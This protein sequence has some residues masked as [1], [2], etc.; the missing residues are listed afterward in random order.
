MSI[1]AFVD[2][3]PLVSSLIPPIVLLSY[4]HT[5]I[6]LGD[7]SRWRETHIAIANRKWGPATAYYGLAHNL[8]PSC[9]TPYHQLAV[10]ALETG[11]HLQ[12]IYHLYRA[13]VV[14]DPHP[15][16]QMSLERTFRKVLEA[17]SKDNSL[18]NYDPKIPHGNGKT[19]F[20][21]YVRLHAKCYMGLD[22]SEEDELEHDVLD[23]LKSYIR[24]QPN[25]ERL[26]HFVLINVA[27]GHL[28]ETRLKGNL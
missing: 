11:S 5:L 25:E 2:T 6:R 15:S 28:A 1:E 17:S 21:N 4:F 8:C 19:L 9:G 10:I 7:L 3:S 27:A 22:L 24:E 14:D 16:A 23:R 13:L 20:E 12:V 26:S 18:I